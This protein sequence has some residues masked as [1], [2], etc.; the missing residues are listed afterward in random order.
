[1][2]V[3]ALCLFFLFGFFRME[4]F[5]STKSELLFYDGEVV[6]LV[7]RVLVRAEDAE[8]VH[9]LRH[10]VAQQL[11]QGARVLGRDLAGSG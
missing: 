2:F 5:Q 10:H 4:T 11:A 1:M 8:V 7:G 3:F 6:E 9:V